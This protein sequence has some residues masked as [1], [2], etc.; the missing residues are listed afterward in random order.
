MYSKYSQPTDEENFS[1]LS[2]A[3]ARA[4]I[5]QMT[6]EDVC[7][8]LDR[9][10]QQ[11]PRVRDDLISR[12]RACC[13]NNPSDVEYAHALVMELIAMKEGQIAPRKRQS[14][15][16]VIKEIAN[17]LPVEEQVDLIPRFLTH[18]R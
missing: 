6:A 15:E 2:G 12:L 9:T 5:C 17:L 7:L 10:F 1:R 16:Y 18:Q 3:V 13:E 14:L 4:L 8:N 11:T